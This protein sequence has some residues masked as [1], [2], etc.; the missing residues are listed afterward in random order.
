MAL[1]MNGRPVDKGLIASIYTEVQKKI[2]K[3]ESSDTFVLVMSLNQGMNRRVFTKDDI[4]NFSNLV[5]KLYVQAAPQMAESFDLG[6]LGHLTAFFSL[7]DCIKYVPSEFWTKNVEPAL[8]EQMDNLQRY[9][10]QINVKQFVFDLSKCLV[11]SAIHRV[12]TS[13]FVG[14]VEHTLRNDVEDF[15]PQTA[16]NLLFFLS[17]ASQNHTS[18]FIASILKHIE[19]ENWLKEGKIYDHVL[20]SDLILENR[21]VIADKNSTLL[22]QLEEAAC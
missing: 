9:R 8:E 10:N 18:S 11:T 2:D 20:L 7:P 19:S 17:R 13:I 22:E 5:Y 12:N 1:A 4:P 16:Q 3:A 15:D 14:V 21:Q 6:Q